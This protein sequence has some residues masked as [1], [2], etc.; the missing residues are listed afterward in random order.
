[1]LG[2]NQLGTFQ[3]G[4][5]DEEVLIAACAQALSLID[6]PHKQSYGQSQTFIDYRWS[7]PAGTYTADG[8]GTSALSSTQTLPHGRVT[9]FVI[10]TLGTGSNHLFFRSSVDGDLGDIFLPSPGTYTISVNTSGNV[11][12]MMSNAPGHWL[13]VAD[14]SYWTFF[15]LQGFAQA[16]VKIT[17]PFGQAQAQAH[18]TK[19]VNNF[20]QAQALV[21][22][23]VNNFA[24]ANALIFSYLVQVKRGANVE[25]LTFNTAVTPGNLL[26]YGSAVRSPGTFSVPSGWTDSG[27]GRVLG[28][29][30]AVV[31]GYRIAEDGDGLLNVNAQ[32]TTNP[33]EVVMFIAEFSNVDSTITDVVSLGSSGATYNP[34]TLIALGPSL[35]V[36]AVAVNTVN[37]PAV[38]PSAGTT[39]IADIGLVGAFQPLIW[40]AFK[41]TEGGSSSISGT[42]PNAGW[43]GITF[44]MGLNLKPKH[45]QAQTFIYGQFFSY[46]QAQAAIKTVDREAFGQ[47]KVDIRVTSRVF[48]QAKALIQPLDGIVRIYHDSGTIDSFRGPAMPG[49]P[50][51]LNFTGSWG[52][53]AAFV[54][55]ETGT[56]NFRVYVDFAGTFYINNTVITSGTYENGPYISGS[57]SLV[58]GQVYTLHMDYFGEAL[59]N[60]L[61][62]WYQRPSD[63]EFYYLTD[64]IPP[65]IPIALQQKYGQ[66]QVK[67]VSTQFPNAQSQAQILSVSKQFAQAQALIEAQG[68][69]GY[70]QSQAQIKQTY[71]FVFVDI[72]YATINNGATAT[73]SNTTDGN[74]TN[75]IDEDSLSYWA[76]LDGL[77]QWIRIDLGQVRTIT[78]YR[79]AVVGY[80]PTVKLQYSTDDSTWIDVITGINFPLDN[81]QVFGIFDSIDARYWRLYSTAINTVDGFG[82][83]AFEIGVTTV[84]GATFAQAQALFGHYQVAQSQARIVGIG[85]KVGQAQAYIGHF[86]SGQAQ[87]LIGHIHSAQAQAR[88]IRI[89]LVSGNTQTYIRPLTGIGLTQAYLRSF[90]QPNFAQANVD[91]LVITFVRG[92]AKVFITKT[93]GHAQALALIKS[94]RT[95]AYGQARV[96][97][98]HFQSGQA[99]AVI[100]KPSVF[101]QAQT[102]IKLIRRV[103]GQAN[104]SILQLQYRGFGQA[105]AQINQTYRYSG[106]AQSLIDWRFAFSQARMHILRQGEIKSGQAQVRIKQSYQV[107]GQAQVN[108]R[109]RY[110]EHAQ[111]QVDIR[112]ILQQTGQAQVQVGGFQFAQV[113]TQIVSFNVLKVAQAQAYTKLDQTTI[114]PITVPNS[115]N[116]TYLVKYNDY[117]LPGYAQDEA[118]D[119]V[120]RLNVL[121]AAYH[122][123][124]YPESLGLSNKVITLRMRLWEPSYREVKE[125]AQKAFTMLRS[126]KGFR[127]LYIQYFDKYYLALVK[128]VQIDKTVEESGRILDYTI[129]FECLPWLYGNEVDEPP[130]EPP[131]PIGP[132]TPPLPPEGQRT[133]FG[134]VMAYIS[135]FGTVRSGQAQTSV[136]LPY[137]FSQTQALIKKSTGFGQ[138]QVRITG[139]VNRVGQAQTRIFKPAGY[140]QARVRVVITNRAFVGQARVFIRKPSGYGQAQAKISG[141]AYKFAQARVKISRP[142]AQG[143]A[144]AFIAILPTAPRN[145][146]ASSGNQSVTLSWQPPTYI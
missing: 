61:Q 51:F 56:W 27:A 49:F 46:G 14:V 36:S 71:P 91:I 89:G 129:E 108:I 99:Q 130:T 125:K 123:G 132:V 95:K 146:V 59:P 113:Q 42:G 143:Q 3:L 31:L 60:I 38:T 28:G 40:G 75:V 25:S 139:T 94:G 7:I 69:K 2:T 13:V 29:T 70:S 145:L 22:K 6:S 64:N 34:G 120:L 88:I 101:A 92:Q 15:P 45:A 17:T 105:Q 18:V 133:E 93:K 86:Q 5:S 98:G 30:R 106:Q 137:G 112:R 68:G 32:W 80:D 127:K 62:I 124:S 26:V 73:A 138:A 41:F 77:N 21:T 90:D 54:A 50:E 107:N 141:R 43:A 111:A 84:Y 39:E 83:I 82:L 144:Q 134:L 52:I 79:A 115:E 20:G 142:F 117:T 74:P 67:L 119:S 76:T 135:S 57:I 87:V 8:T 131:G 9:M 33:S 12:P 103:S 102:Y 24:Q 65:W 104:A 81:T 116:Y 110:Y 121:K 72:N 136:Y 126:A 140:G 48:A 10:V 66:A 55:D 1:M 114:P 11:T 63:T 85:T 118:Y 47:A 100:L 97:I 44:L 78:G 58:A 128:S 53:S 122:D 35:L 23:A 96:R 109:I 4:E 19:I 16:Q 37:E